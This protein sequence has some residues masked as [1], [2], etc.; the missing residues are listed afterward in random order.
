M[1]LGGPEILVILLVALLVFG[2]NKIPDVARQ[3]GRGMREI[4]RLQDNLRG[5]VADLLDLHDDEPPSY[6]SYDAASQASGTATPVP[7]T[8]ATR[9]RPLRSAPARPVPGPAPHAMPSRFRTPSGGRVATPP[10]EPVVTPAA[11]PSPAPATTRARA[12][13]S[14]FRAPRPPAAS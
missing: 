4:R 5:D 13:P 9:P 2:P 8:L 11:S 6:P 14:R 7:S 12:A 3:V 10:R 1:N